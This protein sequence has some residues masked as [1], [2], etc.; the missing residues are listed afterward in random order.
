MVADS[1]P[2]VAEDHFHL[3]LSSPNLDFQH[4]S[5]FPRGNS[6]HIPH[7]QICLLLNGT[8]GIQNNSNWSSARTLCITLVWGTYPCPTLSLHDTSCPDQ[9]ECRNQTP[10]SLRLLH[11][12]HILPASPSC[13]TCKLARSI[14]GARKLTLVGRPP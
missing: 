9:L 13:L 1:I 14:P 11:I 3:Q 4:R 6:R 2:E 5:Y 10:G 12:G 7:I 8:S